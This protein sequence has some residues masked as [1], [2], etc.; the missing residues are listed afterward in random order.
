MGPQELGRMEHLDAQHPS[1]LLTTLTLDTD[2][3][4]IKLHRTSS[5]LPIFSISFPHLPTRVVTHD[6]RRTYATETPRD[7]DHALSMSV[8]PDH[9]YAASI[10]AL[11]GEGLPQQAV[12]RLHGLVQSFTVARQPE[13]AITNTAIQL[14]MKDRGYSL[15]VVTIDGTS[16]TPNYVYAA[17]ILPHLVEGNLPKDK[18]ELFRFEG[19]M[20]E[21]SRGALEGFRDRLG[22]FVGLELQKK[23]QDAIRDFLHADTATIVS[24][25]QFHQAIPRSIQPYMVV[26]RY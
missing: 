7:V 9:R 19:Y 23:P 15:S 12:A 8:I 2:D 16:I 13:V 22:V 20:A 25:G 18:D 6:V 3:E 4:D 24:S 1:H 10:K 17:G 26:K 11:V 21:V 14:I 5:K